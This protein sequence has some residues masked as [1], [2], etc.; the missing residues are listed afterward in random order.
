[1]LHRASR[2]AGLCSAFPPKINVESNPP[3]SSTSSNGWTRYSTATSTAGAVP[4]VSTDEWGCFCPRFIFVPLPAFRIH[5]SSF[6]PSA[7][8]VLVSEETAAEDVDVRCEDPEIDVNIPV[9]VR[10]SAVL[11]PASEKPAMDADAYGVYVRIR[12]LA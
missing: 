10:S 6:V 3:V 4:D 1:M 5:L 8:L 12:R 2:D 9:V 11:I 7:A